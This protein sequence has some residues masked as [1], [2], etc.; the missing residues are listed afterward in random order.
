MRTTPYCSLRVG[1]SRASRLFA[2]AKMGSDNFW[3]KG[4]FDDENGRT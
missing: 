4:Q 1:Q 2:N 3:K